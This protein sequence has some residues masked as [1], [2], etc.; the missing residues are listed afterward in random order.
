MK[1]TLF[2]SCLFICCVFLAIT[3]AIA[4]TIKLKNGSVI[5]GKVT[6]FNDR[7]FTIMLDLGSATKRT[8]SR[9]VIAVD[10][11]ESIQFDSGDLASAATLPSTESGE[12]LIAKDSSTPAAKENPAAG[13]STAQPTFTNA[14]ASAKPTSA[15]EP[16]ISEKSILVAAAADWT[17]TEIKVKKGQRISITATGQVDLGSNRISSPNGIQ[18]SDPK[19]LILT[20]PTGSLI[21]VIGDDNDEFIHIGNQADFV[22]E[23][24]GVLFLSIN[25]GN[26]KD[27]N[28][29][30]SAKVRVLGK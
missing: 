3:V 27:N 7:E 2:R 4:D 15:S 25:E 19:R 12:R 13:Q 28:G 17:S 23:R 1:T 8:S 26:L 14:P 22:A 5:K 10:D 16:A 9:M 6:T 30:F 24:D 29:S 20:S 18:L 21:A 11:V